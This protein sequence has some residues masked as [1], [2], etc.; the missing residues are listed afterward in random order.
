MLA[1]AIPVF[2]A[3]SVISIELDRT[4]AQVGDLISATIRV[5]NVT[6]NFITV[7][8]HFNA[9]VV[10]VIDNVGN[11]VRSGAKTAAQVR[12]GSVGL[13]PGQALS[14]EWAEN[15]QP[16]FWNGGIFENPQYPAIDNEN[17]LIRLMFN[18]AR[19]RAIVNETL[20]TVNF[21][22]VG[23]G[24][25]DIRFAV[26]G[27]AA[28]DTT[29][30]GGAD[31]LP[32]APP[33]TMTA[34]PSEYFSQVNVQSLTVTA[35]DTP[36]NP[37]PVQQP[38]TGNDNDNTTAVIT[39]PSVQ[40][41]TLTYTL[42]VQQVENLLARA[43]GETNSEL[44]IRFDAS[45]NITT[46]IIRMPVEAVELAL[47]SLVF[48]TEFETP[49]GRIGFDHFDVID[50]ALP[51]SQFVIATI[52]ANEWS[53]TIDGV[54]LIA[55]PDGEH[56][57]R[58][59]F[60][61]LPPSH[62]SYRYIM[63]LVERGILNGISATH[64]ASD[65]NVTREQFARMLVS[66]LDIYDESA[67]VNFPDLDTTHWAFTSVASAVNAGIILGHYDG[68]FG[69][70]SNITRQ[71]MAVMITRAIENLPQTNAT[72]EFIDQADIASW[73]ADAV[74][75]M[76]QAGIINGFED[77]TFRPLSNATRAQAARIIY[78]MLAL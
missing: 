11:L 49:I 55:E 37:P 45:S 66:S 52:S 25:A 1:T 6:P 17:G 54:P 70:E 33:G 19:P 64:F 67:T 59:D 44:N 78:G 58:P 35:S 56:T 61:D 29:A 73:A 31:F 7:P 9:D 46:F 8:I 40:N 62:W 51:T 47:M 34:I 39:P 65:Y 71:E 30:P 3:D 38:G 13:T 60:A 26:Q 28:Y 21:I 63:S 18:N 42:T 69:T 76:Q 4:T 12:N 48:S 2:A 20:I 10:Q 53:V 27:D 72:Q 43:F 32:F 23:E 57:G 24:D 5:Q 15:Y 50:N 16:L 68:T 77:R 22:A 14:N 75:A 41:D 74:N 36:F